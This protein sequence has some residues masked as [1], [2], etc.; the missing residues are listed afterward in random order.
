MRQHCLMH[1]RYALLGIARII[2]FIH[3][4]IKNLKTR[5]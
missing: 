4:I 5:T 3:Y 1:S 2:S